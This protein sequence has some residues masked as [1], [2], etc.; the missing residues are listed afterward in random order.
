MATQGRW[1]V[2]FITAGLLGVLLILGGVA[3]FQL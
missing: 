2:R 1:R 3:L